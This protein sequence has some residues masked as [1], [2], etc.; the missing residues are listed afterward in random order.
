MPEFVLEFA[1]EIQL[2]FRDGFCSLSIPTSKKF[3]SIKNEQFFEVAFWIL[4]YNTLLKKKKGHW[5]RS[6]QN[7]T[8]YHRIINLIRNLQILLWYLNIYS[9]ISK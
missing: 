6:L 7:N 2:K 1:C 5:K 8:I 3:V 9:K 4:K